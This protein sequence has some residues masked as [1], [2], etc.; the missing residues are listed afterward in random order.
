MIYS[1][2]LTFFF[3]FLSFFRKKSKFLTV[4][5]LFYI[6]LLWGWNY[7]NGDYEAYERKY[8]FFLT[9]V[10]DSNYEIGYSALMILSN[11]FGLDFQQFFQVVSL[12][13]IICWGRFI[14]FFSKTP[15]LY[16]II[17]LFVFFPL[18]YV[19]LRNTLAFSIVLQGLL[20]IMKN[21][22]YKYIKYILCVLLASTIHSSAL[23]YLSLIIAFKFKRINKLHVVFGV[24]FTLLI[25][26]LYKGILLNY[27]GD[28]S[29]GRAV[30]YSHTIM[31]F[32][33]FS[34]IQIL[35]YIII[36]VCYK[37]MNNLEGGIYN[38]FIR[39]NLILLFL[40]V[41][42]FVLSITVRLFRNIA[43]VNTLLMLNICSC[44]FKNIIKYKILLLLYIITLFLMFIL[45]VIDDT[46]L[47]LYKYNLLFN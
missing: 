43:I 3:I 35:N 19:L 21:A 23:F 20:S 45:P 4:I 13:I 38:M 7:W 31:A 11:Q 42:Y 36:H 30:A 18:D 8:N 24:I 41:L 25:A 26:I 34:V 46:L 44:Y 28:N 6:W 32:L 16:S 22:K 10:L 14:L 47:S 2:L 39:V 5:I 15:A 27:L 37:R 29:E 33:Y 17:L 1:V 40:I 9:N 12:L